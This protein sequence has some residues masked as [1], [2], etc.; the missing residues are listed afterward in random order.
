MA[1]I[2]SFSAV[3][4]TGVYFASIAL[5]LA[6][7]SC[8]YLVGRRARRRRK[9]REEDASMGSAVAATLGL[10]A[11][12][13]ALTFNMSAERFGQRKALLLDEVNAIGT[14]YLRADFL[15][16]ENRNRARELLRE[17]ASL[18]SFDPHTMTPQS[19][20]RDIWRSEEIHRALW[21]LVAMEVAGGT[22][23]SRLRAFYE[24]LNNVI[25]LH[26]ERVQV[27]LAYHIPAPIWAALYV[28]SALAVFGIGFQLG[29][30]GSG[31]KL[32]ALAMAM[33]FALV[34]LLI[35]DLDRASEG[36][37]LVDQSPMREL[38]RQLQQDGQAAPQ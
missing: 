1:T 23:S 14:T 4:L 37:L 19:F 7:L 25:D 3:S 20:E 11:F 10:L 18:R 38:A 16:S 26:T 27:G 17:Y 9:E 35:A 34:I 30:S 24:P 31:S 13:L 2:G 22:D 15:Q 32:V 29:V 33:A 6:A 21:Q 8:G 12:M 5:V 28:I 36:M